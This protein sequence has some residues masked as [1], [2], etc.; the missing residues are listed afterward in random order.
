ML[1][2]GGVSYI[3][4]SLIGKKSGI[5]CFFVQKTV[6]TD[7]GQFHVCDPLPRSFATSLEAP[8]LSLNMPILGYGMV[9]TFSGAAGLP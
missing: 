3:R 4:R 5:F 7:H 1:N 8:G 9:F 6:L 2:F